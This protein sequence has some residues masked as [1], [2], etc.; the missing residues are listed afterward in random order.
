MT[1][2]ACDIADAMLALSLNPKRSK[3]DA[4]SKIAEEFLDRGGASVP[5]KKTGT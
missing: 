1:P 5:G 4:I 3:K 2:T